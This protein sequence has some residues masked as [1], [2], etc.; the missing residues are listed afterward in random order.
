MLRLY[1]LCE[2]VHEWCSDWYA[3]WCDAGYYRVAPRRDAHG[4]E[5]GTR[6]VCGEARGA[7]A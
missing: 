5:S 1:D 6:R 3:D 2:N 4:P 7:T